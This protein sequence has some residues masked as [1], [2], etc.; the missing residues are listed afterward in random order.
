M[1][2]TDLP[3]DSSYMLKKRSGDSAIGTQTAFV[4]F[5]AKALDTKDVIKMQRSTGRNS[6]Q[7]KGSHKLKSQDTTRRAEM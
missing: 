2:A 6:E 1:K 7:H 4:Y 3:R 5:G